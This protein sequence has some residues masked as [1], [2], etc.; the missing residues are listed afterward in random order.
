MGLEMMVQ[1]EQVLLLHLLQQEKDM[2]E[3]QKGVKL[4]FGVDC[5]ACQE[6]PCSVVMATWPRQDEASVGLVMVHLWA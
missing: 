4:H 1:S 5:L 2:V 6:E 3:S